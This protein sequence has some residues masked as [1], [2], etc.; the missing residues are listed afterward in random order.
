MGKIKNDGNADR[1]YKDSSSTQSNIDEENFLFIKWCIKVPIHIVRF[2][3]LYGWFFSY[4][5][6][7]GLIDNMDKLDFDF[8]NNF[9][10]NIAIIIGIVLLIYFYFELQKNFATYKEL[11]SLD[12]G[13][14]ASS[15]RFIFSMLIPALVVFL[16]DRY[17]W[18]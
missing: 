11:R 8:N 2:I 1:R 4:E 17:S 15:S 12:M 9:N 16:L 3:F 18:L 5:G 14:L 10:F 7:L 6:V 13:I